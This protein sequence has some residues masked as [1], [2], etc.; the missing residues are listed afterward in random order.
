VRELSLRERGCS[1]ANSEHKVGRLRESVLAWFRENG[2][3]FPWR[4][5]SNPFHV[6][7]AEFLLRQTQATRLVQPYLEL[8]SKYPDAYALAEADVS[9]LRT[10]FK[11]LGL[12]TRADY[13]VQTV[14]ILVQS[15]GGKVPDDLDTLMALP[16]LGLYSA[17]AVLCLGFGKPYPMVDEASGRVLRRTLDLATKGPAYSDSRLLKMAEAVLPK[18]SCKEFNLG[19]IDIA[20]FYCHPASP[21]CNR[22][23]LATICSYREC[24]YK[25]GSS[26]VF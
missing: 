24:S 25:E 4:Q 12:V 11:P 19:L 10:W 22:C 18:A 21:E 1:V 5:T 20:A 8:T 16:G 7:L 23:P 15:Y 26:E 9:S 6:L 13:L 17:R 14:H 2:R 3:R